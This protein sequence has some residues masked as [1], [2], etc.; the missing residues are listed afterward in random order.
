MRFKKKNIIIIGIVLGIIAGYAYWS[1]I[2]CSSGSCGMTSTWY[3]SSL[4]G[5]AVGYF[6]GDSIKLNDKEKVKD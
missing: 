4:V 3:G 1:F 2:G 6:I 5:G